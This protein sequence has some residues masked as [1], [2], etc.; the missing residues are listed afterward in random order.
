MREPRGDIL[1]RRIPREKIWKLALTRTPDP[2]RPS[3][4][5]IFVENCHKPVLLTLT[6]PRGGG[7]TNPYSCFLILS[8]YI[9]VGYPVVSLCTQ[10]LTKPW[11]K[12]DFKW[13]EIQKNWRQRCTRT[14]WGSSPDPRSWILGSG[15]S[16]E[17]HWGEGRGVW[18][19]GSAHWVKVH[20][21]RRR[22][23]W[24][25]EAVIDR[26]LRQLEIHHYGARRD[27]TTS[28]TKEAIHPE[29]PHGDPRIHASS[30]AD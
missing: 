29:G 18:I 17:V 21:T 22:V 20:R 14:H 25:T 3:R 2:N 23:A 1:T 28:M 5:G 13:S 9:R 19:S 8:D 12:S 10:K 27:V 16:R 7:C 15:R 26:R 30:A 11:E 6:D 4:R 24:E